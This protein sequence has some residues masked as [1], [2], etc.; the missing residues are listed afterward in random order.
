MRLEL[1]D[2]V[3]EREGR[4]GLDGIS[5]TVEAGQSLGILGPSGSGVSLLLKTAAGLLDPTAGRVLYDGVDL[6]GM[7]AEERRLLQTRTGFMFQ[8]AALWANSPVRNNLLLPLQAKHPRTPTRQLRREMAAQ[9]ERLGFQEDLNQRPD[10]LSLGQQR[11]VSFLRAVVP[12]PGALFLDEPHNS[13]DL[14]WIRVL[15]QETRRLHEQG[16]TVITGSH[17]SAR[18]CDGLDHL[19][20]LDRGRVVQSGT[21]DQVRQNLASTPRDGDD[22]ASA[23]LEVEPW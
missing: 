20:I 1:Q 18:W 17:R 2:V 12:G 14:H 5:L 19:I 9:L 22:P 15:D 4:R 8:D 10:R 23:F 21:P 11:F 13:M 16:T 7:G 6:R 3:V